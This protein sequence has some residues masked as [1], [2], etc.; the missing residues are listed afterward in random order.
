MQWLLHKMAT[1]RG[2]ILNDSMGLGKVRPPLPLPAA[3]CPPA[4][5]L[6][7]PFP[8]RRLPA[9]CRRCR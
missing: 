5:T 6:T 1:R 3:C 4:L 2:A 8:A 7:R 9:G